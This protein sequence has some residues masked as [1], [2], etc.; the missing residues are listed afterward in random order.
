MI[1]FDVVRYL[2]ADATLDTLLGVTG[3]D[4]KI[5]PLQAPSGTVIPFILYTP[6][7]GD[8]ES[9]VIYE[10]RLQLVPISTD[11]EEVTNIRNRLRALLDLQD[12]IQDTTLNSGSASYYI[13]WSKRTGGNIIMN[14]DRTRYHS[15]NIYNI[16]FLDK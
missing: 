4:S 12:L 2:K 1:E 11:V 8:T 14:E 16:K 15:I 13:Y 7:V 10:D 5:Y 9:E 6:G 3:T